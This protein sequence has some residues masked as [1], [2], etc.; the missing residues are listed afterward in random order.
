MDEPFKSLDYDLRMNMVEAL[1]DI[2]HKWNNAVVFVT[3]EIDEA[4]LLGNKIVVLAK[5][6]CRVEAT[7]NIDVPQKQRSLEDRELINVRTKLINMLSKE[8]ET[9]TYK[10]A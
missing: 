8:K 4:I 7:V 10:S 5:N 2:W 9:S 6:P 3:H 1:I